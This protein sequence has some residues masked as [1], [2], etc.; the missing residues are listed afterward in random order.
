LFEP[1]LPVGE[2]FGVGSC[3]RRFGILRAFRT[4]RR[5][6]RLHQFGTFPGCRVDPE[7]HKCLA[8]CSAKLACELGIV[9]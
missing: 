8:P 6:K 3:H 4:W 9:H 5:E 1:L 7:R 2:E